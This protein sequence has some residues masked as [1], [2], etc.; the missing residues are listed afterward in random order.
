MAGLG[1][2]LGYVPR[3]PAEFVTSGLQTPAPVPIGGIG[4]T[5][6]KTI[7]K[8]IV[9]GGLGKAAIIGGGG[10]L[11]GLILGGGGGQEQKQELAQTGRVDPKQQWRDLV[12]TTEQKWRD[13]LL[14]AELKQKQQQIVKPEIVPT[15]TTTYDVTAGG[16]VEIGGVTTTTKTKT[17]TTNIQ[18]AAQDLTP[19]ITAVTSPM[20]S[21]SALLEQIAKQTA[22]QERTDLGL[23]ALVVVGAMLLLGLGG[24]RGR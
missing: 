2:F 20:V 3:T 12:A 14:K 24:K 1:G 21:Q 19:I 15:V 8:H 13:L 11:A 4:A 9:K 5:V 22:T 6:S 18:Q 7:T 10:L 17:I 23:I 16:D